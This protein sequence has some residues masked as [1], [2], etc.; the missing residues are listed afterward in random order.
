MKGL[1]GYHLVCDASNSVAVAHLRERKFRKEKP[2][3]IMAKNCEIANKLV[4]L[5]PE[6]LDLLTSS[7]SPH[8]AR[9]GQG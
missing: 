6:A 8:R 4:E 2:F 3:A 5:S 7:A 9:S 1:G